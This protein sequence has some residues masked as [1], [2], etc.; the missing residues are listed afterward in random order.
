MRSDLMLHPGDRW[1]GFLGKTEECTSD[2]RIV[3]AS[4]SA[5]NDLES[6]FE[7]L[8]AAI[9]TVGSDRVEGI[10][11]REDPR[12]NGNLFCLQAA[13][14]T[15]AIVTFMMRPGQLRG[16][17]EKRDLLD[18]IISG[19]HALLHEHALLRGEGTWFEEYAVGEGELPNVMKVCAHGNRFPAG[20]RRGPWPWRFPAQS[21]KRAG[22]GPRLRRHEDPSTMRTRVL[23]ER[24][25]G[26]WAVRASAA[27]VRTLSEVSIPRI[28]SLWV[29]GQTSFGRH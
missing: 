22:S 5:S 20:F 11:H 6:F 28:S 4:R 17:R 9:G 24:L 29:G 23:G 15:A 8:S 13:Q 12:A 7:R 10:R 16:I 1:P 25:T 19:L 3:Q 27:G 21:D 2:L 18:Q 14:I 26:A